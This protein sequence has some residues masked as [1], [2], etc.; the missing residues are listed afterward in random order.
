MTE[1]QKKEILSMRIK[2]M[3]YGEIA[4]GL[5]LSINTVKSF[6]HRNEG[7]C[8]QCGMPVQQLTGRKHKRF[9]S[10]SCRIRWW[11]AHKDL[12]NRRRFYEVRCSYCQRDFYVY[13]KNKR[14]YCSHQCYIN[15]RFGGNNEE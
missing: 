11:N 7:K 4:K 3:G 2:G 14:K 13:G 5:E 10:D 9:C 12:V 1:I 15:E 8:E 6:C